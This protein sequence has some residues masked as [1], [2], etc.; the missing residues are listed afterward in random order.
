[1]MLFLNEQMYFLN[2]IWHLS[3]FQQEVLII[4]VISKCLRFH[5]PIRTALP[6]EDFKPIKSY[7]MLKWCV[8]V[9]RTA[10]RIL[11]MAS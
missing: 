11:A 9:H 10:F 8:L 1:M 7:C 4:H 6:L 3:I 5:L 2:F